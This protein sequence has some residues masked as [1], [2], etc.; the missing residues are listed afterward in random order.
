MP[1]LSYTLRLSASLSTAYA[2]PTSLNFF[3][4]SSSLPTFLSGCHF[5]A[6]LRYAFLMSDSEAC[7]VC[8]GGVTRANGEVK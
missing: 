2:S 7:S 3:V 4:A 5:I 6:F 8:L 1:N